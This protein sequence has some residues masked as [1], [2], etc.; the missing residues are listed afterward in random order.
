MAIFNSYVKLPE[1]NNSQL[2]E[3]G[4]QLKLHQDFHPISISTTMMPHHSP[5][6]TESYHF[7]QGW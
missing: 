5:M 1:G 4:D 6:P 7:C 2:R 3:L